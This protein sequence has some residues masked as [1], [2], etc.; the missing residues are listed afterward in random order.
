MDDTEDAMDTTDETAVAERPAV[1]APESRGGGSRPT[2]RRQHARKGGVY[3]RRR[4]LAICGVVLVAFL[5]WLAISLGSALT[6]PT[7]GSS[8]SARFPRG[9]LNVQPP[10]S[11]P[12]TVRLLS[13]TWLA[14]ID[15]MGPAANPMTQ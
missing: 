9:S 6:N 8:M 13:R 14:G 3:R 12:T 5:I 1:R 7:Y 4:I 11:T 10:Q 2:A 15:G